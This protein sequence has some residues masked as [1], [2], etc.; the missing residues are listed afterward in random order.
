MTA[1]T[2][3]VVLITGASAG[4]GQALA[5]EA[6][7]KGYRLALT[8]RRR[9]RLEHLASE[10]T[11]ETL[12]ISAALDDPETPSRLVG[13]TLEHFGRLDALIN[14][15][16]FG[17]PSLFATSEPDEIRRQIEVNFTAPLLLTRYALPALL[18]SKGV[19][20]N[21][22]SAITC[23]ENSGL[24]AYGATK[25]GLGYWSIAL[26]R[27]LMHRG[28]RVCLVEPGPVHTE[29]FDAFTRLG[30][31]PGSYHAMLDAPAGWLSAPVDD[32]ARRI[33][34]LLEKPKRRLSVRK[35]FVWPWRL[36]GGFFQL[37]PGLADLAVSGVVRY[38]EH[39]GPRT[40]DPSRRETKCEGAAAE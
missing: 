16:G 5:R 1:T 30:A 36:L 2:G 15:A 20:I 40:V 8:A 4:I 22:G 6:S 3:K 13:S 25:A 38:Y 10:L 33:L 26:R 9:D 39:S 17:L 35:R 34:R 19:V 31:E 24:G 27:E 23:I 29:F 14:N 28:V 11:T 37:V 7:K 12:I 18:E 32:V 21:I